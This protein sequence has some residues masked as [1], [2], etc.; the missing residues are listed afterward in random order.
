MVTKNE[1]TEK[2]KKRTKS[3]D[4]KLNDFAVIETGGKQYI[5]EVGTIIS[6]EKLTSENKT[7]NFDKVLLKSINDNVTVGTPYIE[8]ESVTAEILST[9]KDKKIRVFKFKKKTGYKKTQGHRQTL[10][11]VRILSLSAESKSK[12]TAK[13]KVSDK[14]DSSKETKGV[15]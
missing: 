7:L 15:K 13:S 1:E 9:E 12:K 14:I 2:L 8:N 5:V 6:V 4:E 11:T 3:T 10:S